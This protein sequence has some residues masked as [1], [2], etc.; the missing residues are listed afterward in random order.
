MPRHAPSICSLGK[1]S[2]VEDGQRRLGVE[3]IAAG[4]GWRQCGAS[5]AMTKDWEERARTG[6][7]GRRG[8]QGTVAWV[9]QRSWTSGGGREQARRGGGRDWRPSPPCAVRSG[10][11]ASAV[12]VPCKGPPAG[13]LLSALAGRDG[14]E[15]HVSGGWWAAHRRGRAATGNPSPE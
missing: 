8:T 1:Q 7:G 4:D 11:R 15:Q 10:R 6:S 14:S 9:N 3:A 13:L 5:A 2:V 12:A